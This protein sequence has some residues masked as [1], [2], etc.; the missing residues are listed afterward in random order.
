MT[1]HQHP[2]PDPCDDLVEHDNGFWT[3]YRAAEEPPH[4]PWAGW[5]TFWALVLC[6][7]AVLVVTHIWSVN[8][9]PVAPWQHLENVR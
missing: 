5:D 2:E 3:D 6:I 8:R 1:A 4:V 9:A 7:V